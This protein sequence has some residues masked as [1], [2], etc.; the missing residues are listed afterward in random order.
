[1]SAIEYRAE[2]FLSVAPDVISFTIVRN[3][4]V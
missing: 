2:S 4:P 3:I 1:M